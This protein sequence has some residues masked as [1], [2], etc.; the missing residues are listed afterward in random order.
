MTVPNKYRLNMKGM[1]SRKTTEDYI[2]LLYALEDQLITSP[3]VR[4]VF[5]DRQDKYTGKKCLVV[6]VKFADPL[7]PHTTLQKF[8]NSAKELCDMAIYVQRFDESIYRFY[9]ETDKIIN[10]YHV[11][12]SSALAH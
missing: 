7:P 12:K 10:T 1:N 3:Y 9:D 8:S 6:V 11:D 5:I 4:S 2:S